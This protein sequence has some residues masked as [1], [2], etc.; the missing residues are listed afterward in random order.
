MR[1]STFVYSALLFVAAAGLS[2]APSPQFRCKDHRR[3]FARGCLRALSAEGYNWADVDA[4]GLQVFFIGNAPDEATRFTA[5]SV[6]GTVVDAARVIDQMTV[7]ETR[8]VA[9]PEFRL[10]FLR[11]A[12]GVSVFGVLPR[13]FGTED[14][15]SELKKSSAPIN[16]LRSCLE[17]LNI[18][19]QIIGR[20]L[21]ALPWR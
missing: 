4:D 1:I 20:K 14:L 8:D 21:C 7:I 13:R 12:T 11:S 19:R 5:K 3:H 10:E 16:A 6:A 2:V 9:P 18:P 17:M 15:I